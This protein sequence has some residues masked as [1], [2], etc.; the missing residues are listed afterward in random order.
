MFCLG[1]SLCG[2]EQGAKPRAGWFLGGYV[3]ALH[4]CVRGGV[5]LGLLLDGRLAG[6]LDQHRCVVETRLDSEVVPGI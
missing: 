6:W 4:G 3:A 2:V 5:G 1:M